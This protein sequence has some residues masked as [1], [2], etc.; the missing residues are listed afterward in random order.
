MVKELSPHVEQMIEHA[1]ATGLFPSREAMLE[2]SVERLMHEHPL[3]VPQEQLDAIEQALDAL[4]AGLGV[5]WNVEDE[6][7]RYH[8]RR[9]ERQQA[10]DQ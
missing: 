3:P 7:R 9:L 2:A 10:K 6:I 5:E 8:Q 1:V 4:D